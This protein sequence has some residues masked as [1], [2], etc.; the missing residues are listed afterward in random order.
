MKATALAPPPS[1][2]STRVTGTAPLAD[3]QFEV[4]GQTGDAANLTPVVEQLIAVGGLAP[5][6]R[7]ERAVVAVTCQ[8]P[9]TVCAVVSYTKVSV[10]LRMFRSR[11]L[12]V[13]VPSSVLT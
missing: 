1:R 10:S 8:R 7:T 6:Y 2:A 12:S 11:W 13:R 3:I 4:I 9:S 5:T